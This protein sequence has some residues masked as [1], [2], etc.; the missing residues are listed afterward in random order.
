MGFCNVELNRS[1]L[2]KHGGSIEAVVIELSS[3]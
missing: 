3:E 2:D 1:L